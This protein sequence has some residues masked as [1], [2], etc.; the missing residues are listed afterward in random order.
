MKHSKTINAFFYLACLISLSF[1]LSCGDTEDTEET[2]DSIFNPFLDEPD[3]QWLQLEDEDW[4]K[5]KDE[6]WVRLT[7]EEVKELMTLD[8]PQD[9][10]FNTEARV[11]QKYHHATLFQRFGDI[12]QV[13]FIVEFER[14]EISGIV[15][16]ALAKQIAAHAEATYFITP[17]AVTRRSLE[18]TRN[19]LRRVE[20]QEALRLLDQLRIE[21]PEAW[22]KGM[23]AVL[24]ERHGDIREVDTSIDF[25]RKL[26]LGL[27]RTNRDCNTYIKVHET[28]FSRSENF[29]PYAFYAMLEAVNQI[30]RLGSLRR[31]EKYREA[32]EKGISFYDIDWDDE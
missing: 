14:M 6:N 2:I 26:E 22:L 7:D 13:R 28:L 27:P 31:L 5:L 17:N 16:L 19:L 9:W 11:S 1:F 20:E 24:I 21:D 25:F 8:I 30:G 23:R 12:P 4:E 10:G 15:T 32:R 18:E 29:F 3:E